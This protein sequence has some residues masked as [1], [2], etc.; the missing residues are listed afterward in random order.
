MVYTVE[1]VVD[2]LGF[3]LFQLGV[4]MFA[5]AIW[6]RHVYSVSKNSSRGCKGIT[7]R[8]FENGFPSQIGS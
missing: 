4:T 2:K 7:C 5:G 3:G 1:D 6:V 8:P